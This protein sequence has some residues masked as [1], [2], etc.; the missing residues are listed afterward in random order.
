MS[1]RIERFDG[2]PIIAPRGDDWE[3]LATFNPGAIRIGDKIYLLY[4]AIGDYETYSSSLGLAVFDLELNLLE[5]RDK[6]VLEPDLRVWELSIEDPRI[7]KIGDE[8]YVTYV[9]TITPAPPYA[10][11]L[12]IGRR[13]PVQAYSKCAVA[14]TR[15][16]N[17]FERLGIVTPHSAE[18]RNLVLFP[19]RFGG[20]LAALH[21][22]ANWIGSKYGTD[23]PGIWFSWIDGFPGILRDHRL[24]M[25][26]EEKW[27]S[28]KIGAGAPPVKTEKGYL[29]I[30]HGVDE[31]KVYRAGIALLDK[32]EPWRVIARS[33]KPILEPKEDYERDGDVPNVVFP[34]GAVRIGEKL[35]I[36]YGAADKY[37][38]VAF[39][40]LDDLL[41]YL[42]P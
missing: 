21:R 17:E 41:D 34:T 19:D 36:F 24:V 8:I 28:D 33:D 1:V 18:E 11:R 32:D 7:T 23:R 20:R 13:K 10:V 37:C 31:K 6:P 39:A 27:E 30:Y 22:P 5:R 12:R 38:C 25:K 2:N 9:T 3:A 42:I 16:L 4:R 40:D 15:D 26:P 29:L 35:A 14:R